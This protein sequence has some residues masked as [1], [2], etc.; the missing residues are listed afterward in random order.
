VKIEKM[1]SKRLHQLTIKEKPCF[2]MRRQRWTIHG[3]E[4]GAMPGGD[5]RL[6]RC[7]LDNTR[8]VV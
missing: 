8:P 5:I 2:L 6:L 4:T 7:S 3:I 1:W